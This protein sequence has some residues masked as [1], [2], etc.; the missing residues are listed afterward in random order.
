MDIF[1]GKGTQQYSGLV[2]L[3]KELPET[4]TMV[5]VGSANGESATIF[6]QSDKIAKVICVDNWVYKAEGYFDERTANNPKILKVKGESS[7]EAKKHRNKSLDGVY[8]DG[9]HHYL[10]CKKDIRAWLPKI[11]TGGWI[12]GHDYCMQFPGVAL[13]VAEELTGCKPNGKVNHPMVFDDTSWL[14]LNLE[15]EEIK[16]IKK[17]TKKGRPLAE[18]EFIKKLKNKLQRVLILKPKGSPGK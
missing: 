11:R 17:N 5:E 2:D 13:A 3:I 14:V 18:V 8:I 6:T 1:R 15:P 10:D 4:E 9:S 16:K 12:A 7:K